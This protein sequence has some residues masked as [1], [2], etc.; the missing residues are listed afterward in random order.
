MNEIYIP[1]PGDRLGPFLGHPHD[2]RNPDDDGDD[3]TADLINDVR[4]WLDIA[5]DAAGKGD[6]IKAR[7]ALAEA[8]INLDELLQVAQ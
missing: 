6:L 7:G 4:E 2:P 5:Q 8:K 3:A 1:G